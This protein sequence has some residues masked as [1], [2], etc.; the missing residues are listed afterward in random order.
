M[1]CIKNLRREKLHR[2]IFFKSLSTHRVRCYRFVEIQADV[3]WISGFRTLYLRT[4]WTGP[5]PVIMHEDR[6][7]HSG[8]LFSSF[9]HHGGLPTDSALLAH[10]VASDAHVASTILE[11][12]T[13]NAM[14]CYELFWCIRFV[15]CLV[16]VFFLMCFF[17]PSVVPVRLKS[18]FGVEQLIPWWWL[19]VSRINIWPA[20]R[21]H[22]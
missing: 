10:G 8:S 21:K 15:V 7:S 18:S 17:F 19:L 4:K 20:A 22:D 5:S 11:F 2:T 13:S 1:T 14:R 16:V 12:W 9:K 3:F 6:N